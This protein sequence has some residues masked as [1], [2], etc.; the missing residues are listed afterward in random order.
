[1]IQKKIILDMAAVVTFVGIMLS[2]FLCHWYFIAVWQ[3]IALLW[4]KMIEVQMDINN[5]L[6][7]VVALQDEIIQYRKVHSKKKIKK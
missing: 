7:R 5:A 6:V 1:M 2:L 4:I 3:F